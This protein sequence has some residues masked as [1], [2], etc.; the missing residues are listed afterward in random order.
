[1]QYKKESEQQQPATSAYVGVENIPNKGSEGKAVREE[2]GQSGKD[3]DLED[4][5]D[6]Q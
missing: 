3:T 1:M 5:A 4:N 6:D 2:K